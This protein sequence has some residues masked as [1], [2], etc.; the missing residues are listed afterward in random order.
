MFPSRSCLFKS[1]LQFSNVIRQIFS[2]IIRQMRVAEGWPQLVP[3][4][5]S[6]YQL[7]QTCGGSAAGIIYPH[8]CGNQDSKVGELCRAQI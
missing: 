8:S 6:L 7:P 1:F 2:N 4:A 5:K 3:T